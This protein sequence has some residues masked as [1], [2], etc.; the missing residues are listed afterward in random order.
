[1]VDGVGADEINVNTLPKVLLHDHLDGG[2]RIATVLDL[3][4]SQGYGSLPATHEEDL[5]GWF[6][7]GESGSLAR[8]LESFRHTVG[9]MQTAEALERVAYEAVLDTAADGVVYGEFRFAPSNHTRLGLAPTQIVDSTLAGLRRGSEETGMTVG[10][11][12]VAM[13]ERD[14]SPIIARLASSYAHLG[15]VGFDLA[16][17]EREAP[18]DR[19]LV[20]T[21]MVRGANLGL[22]IH[23]GEADGPHSMWTA[24]QR[25]GAHRIGH[26]VHIVDDCKVEGDDI[27]ELGSLATYVRDFRVP[28]EVC[29]TS[30]LHTGPWKPDSHP[31]GALNRA[32]FT[33]TLNTDNRLM[34]RTSLSDEFRL[35]TE[36]QGFELSDL[37][38]VTVNAI[39]AAFAPLPLK[40]RILEERIRPAYT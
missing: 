12:L 3:A 34:S 2:L 38:R 7:Q 9:V 23:A 18:A 29:P 5:A 24:L 11:I 30:N 25:C 26:G 14:D 31:V 16:G 39:M 33:V 40:R 10:L 15:V 37:F 22:T 17:S 36:H 27:T 13:R 21:R 1:M 28:L 32:G 35:V 19:H 4:E 8:Y 20:A 6:F